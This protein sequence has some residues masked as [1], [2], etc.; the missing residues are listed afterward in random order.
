MSECRQ[1][2]GPVETSLRTGKSKLY[3]SKKCSSRWHH[4]NTYTK[5]NEDWG[6]RGERDRVLKEEKLKKREEKNTWIDQYCISRADLAKELDIHETTLWNR[7]KV[8]GLKTHKKVISNGKT[9]KVFTF[10]EREDIEGIRNYKGKS[11][12]AE[13]PLGFMSKPE[14]AAYLGVTETTIITKLKRIREKTGVYPVR[15][16]Y[17]TEVVEG[18]PAK[19]CFY[20][21]E[22]LERV[23]N[24][25][26]REICV[27]VGCEGEFK[28]RK[29]REYCSP[30]CK[31]E[32]VARKKR[33]MARDMGLISYN[34]ATARIGCSPGWASLAESTIKVGSSRY[35]KESKV[36]KLRDAYGVYIQKKNADWV[37]PVIRRKDNWQDWKVREE[38]L[39]TGF[40]AKVK[41]WEAKHGPDSP[42]LTSL[43][44]AIDT[45]HSYH[46][47][48]E[49]TGRVTKLDCSAC[50]RSKP[51]YEFF[52]SARGGT[53]GR[54][55]SR[56]RGCQS[57]INRNAYD[58]AAARLKVDENHVQRIRSGVAGSI[59][60]H[61][62]KVTGVYQVIGT[63][64]I[65]LHIEKTLGYD[66]EDLVT[67]LE[68][69]F[70]PNMH[71]QNQK[72]PRQPGEF[73][74]HMDH[75]VPHVEFR[76]DSID[77]P[78]FYECWSLENL[79]PLEAVVNMQKGNKKL[80]Q[81]FQST[82]RTGIRRAIAGE[83]YTKGV[84]KHLDYSNLEAKKILEKKFPLDGG[85]KWENWGPVWQIDHID[86]VAHLA[87]SS[88]D[89]ENFKK[90]WN[91]SN[92][93]PLTRKEN[94]SKGSEWNNR[95]W[96]HNC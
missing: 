74:W 46:G 30:S 61:M 48:M 51:F 71:W 58:K 13:A 15:R 37:N 80:Y 64:A 81:A 95:L 96:F 18:R 50:K 59:K 45:N 36:E 86:P 44:S 16:Q 63:S 11:Y 82:F 17:V 89:C 85:I 69:Q 53:S 31:V 38:K 12:E 42:R 88:P 33:L 62:A 90:C 93:S 1:C 39:L 76:Y 5:K 24:L 52:F 19:R 34:E 75:I 20:N 21:T 87:Y 83:V 67:H 43:M 28:P 3:C 9:C 77:H 26:F 35:V 57:N 60:R 29:K 92:L 49:V 55:T 47:V 7:M 8:L 27:C 2:R 91:L 84:W 79:R 65:W 70:T 68:S 40:P 72:T 56:C 22:D 78:D 41:R 4:Q 25:D 66:H 14:A 6:T 23:K 54:R 10:I 73:G 32:H 94:A